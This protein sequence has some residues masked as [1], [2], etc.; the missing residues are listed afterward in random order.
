MDDVIMI[1]EIIFANV[2][3]LFIYDWLKSLFHKDGN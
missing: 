1:S 2:A 3:S